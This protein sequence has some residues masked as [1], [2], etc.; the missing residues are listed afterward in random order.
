M[1]DFKVVDVEGLELELTDI[2]DEVRILTDTTEKMTMADMADGVAEANG[3]IDIQS[4]IIANIKD[5]LSNLDDGLTAMSE[6]VSEL[7]DMPEEVNLT[8]MTEGVAAANGEI[9]VQ[10]ELIEQIKEALQGK[11][12]SGKEEQEKSITITENGTYKVLPDENKVLSEVNVEVNIV[13]KEYEWQEDISEI[14]YE[15]TCYQNSN[16]S[17]FITKNGTATYKRNDNEYVSHNPKWSY[18]N[19]NQIGAA[20]TYICDVKQAE[21]VNI[22]GWPPI[23]TLDQSTFC[24]FTSMKVLKLPDTITALGTR[25]FSNCSLMHKFDLPDTIETIGAA[26]FELCTSLEEFTIPPLVKDIKSGCFANCYKLKRVYGIERLDSIDGGFS[27]CPLLSGVITFGSQL[28]TLKGQV[29]RNCCSID[30]FI[31]NSIPS[32]S[33]SADMFN[34]CTGV[35]RFEVPE[36]WNQSLYL[37]TL[38]N[39]EQDYWHRMIEHFADMTGAET[40]PIFRVGSTILKKIDDE[41][42]AMLENKGWDYS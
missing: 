29:F 34:N 26:A 16:V 33:N 11:A 25:V 10:S 39:L 20:A 40:A 36:G 7:V 22:P 28:K 35:T 30:G 3:I 17:L 32:M 19:L 12:I 4:D 23:T 21:V 41:H 24:L 15:K 9:V 13:D 2:A 31:F 37:N 14:V 18:S 1:A 8:T 42:K 5:T 6:E 38:T 27:S